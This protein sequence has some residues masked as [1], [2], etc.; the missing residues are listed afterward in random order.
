[1]D[2]SEEATRGFP[3]TQSGTD[4]GSRGTGGIWSPSSGVPC[5]PQYGDSGS[6]ARFFYTSK[7]DAGDRLGSKHPTVKPVD[8]IAYLCRLICPPGGVILDPFAGSGTT[9]MACVHPHPPA[10]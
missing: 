3:E 9:G 6:A 1:L 8:L 7:A 10:G 2:G 4:D 5:G